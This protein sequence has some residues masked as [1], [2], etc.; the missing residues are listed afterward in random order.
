MKVGR[1]GLWLV[2]V[3]AALLIVVVR[4]AVDSRA[5]LL[6]GRA[7]EAA[8]DLREAIRQ[9]QDAVRM[10][11]PASPFVRG[12]LDRLEALAA[13]AEKTGDR[14]TE[15]AA[16]EALRAGLLG[17]RSFYTPHAD[18]LARAEP[19]LSRL[20][21]EIEDPSVDPGASAP[22]RAAWHAARLA[23]RPGPA[24]GYVILA[25]GG[26]ALWLGAAAGFVSRGLDAGLRLRRGRAIV[27]GLL[28]LVGFTMFL[29][30]LRLA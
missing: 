20:L 28:F 25:L 2:G 9:Y 5:A 4:V 21:A 8:G 23:R 10:F 3:V 24:V 7:A 19:R 15:R 18:R 13:A 16:L 6:A 29:T 14:A 22:A 26:L 1:A 27:A 12:A 17:A 11:L 30:G